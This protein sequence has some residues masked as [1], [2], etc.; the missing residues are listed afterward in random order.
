[1]KLIPGADNGSPLAFMAS[2]NNIRFKM[3]SLREKKDRFRKLDNFS[4]RWVQRCHKAIDRIKHLHSA[5]ERC[6]VLVALAEVLG[7]LRKNPSALASSS[8]WLTRAASIFLASLA[9]L[10]L[11]ASALD[12]SSGVNRLPGCGLTGCL[13]AFFVS[14]GFRRSKRL[15]VGEE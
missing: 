3:N 1:M 2:P 7:A 8:C 14:S 12:F 6:P 10:C 11:S 9:C 13:V 4:L 15:A 5:R